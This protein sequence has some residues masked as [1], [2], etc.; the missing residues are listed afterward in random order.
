MRFKVDENL[1]IEVA[2]MLRQAGHDAATV[3]EQHLGGSDDAQLAVLC[4]LESRILVT[5]DMDFADIRNYPPAEFPGLVVL[6]LRQQ[7][8]PYVLDVFMRCMQ[9]L[10][11][12]PIEGQ[13]WI[14]EE[15]RIR[16]RGEPG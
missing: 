7:D 6:R 9:V 16:I 11:Q 5:L 2:E 3:L 15:N 4:Q 1:P 12:E 14:V 8:K 13:L 10:D